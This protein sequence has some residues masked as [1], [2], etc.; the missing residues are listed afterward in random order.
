MRSLW[1]LGL[2]MTLCASASAASSVRTH[3]SRHSM[4]YHRYYSSYDRYYGY[5]QF[6]RHYGYSQWYGGGP[7]NR[8]GLVGGDDSGT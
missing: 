3:S 5:S 8:G 6:G 1:A 7:N 4:N 2:L